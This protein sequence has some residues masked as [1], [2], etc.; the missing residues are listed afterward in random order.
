[1]TLRLEDKQTIVAEVNGVAS[2]ALS[3]VTAEYRGLTVGQMTRLRAK[4]RNAGV[5]LRVVRNTLARRALEN[6][7]FE[8]LRESLVGPL[9]LAFSLEEPASAARLIRDFA[10]EYEKLAVKAFV[11]EGIL[12]GAK[13]LD[14]LA[15]LPTRD[16]ALSSLMAV[17]KAPIAKFVRTLAEPHA[18]LARTLAALR[19]NKQGG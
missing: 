17:M 6:T 9:L 11:F 12:L 16:E 13:D 19:D 8:S 7:A 4:A 1:M 10:K 14:R 15:N 2:K 3:V 18:K 5:Y